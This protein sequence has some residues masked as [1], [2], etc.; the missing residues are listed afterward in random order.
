MSRG[1]TGL[2]TKTQP[3]SE[4]DVFFDGPD[5]IAWLHIVGTSQFFEVPQ[6]KT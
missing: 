2:K 1:T 3:D 5:P 4:R 6:K